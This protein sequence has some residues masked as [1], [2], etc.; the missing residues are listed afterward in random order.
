MFRFVENR[1]DLG[2]MEWAGESK[3]IYRRLLKSSQSK[4]DYSNTNTIT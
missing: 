4:N 2:V 1:I 3:G